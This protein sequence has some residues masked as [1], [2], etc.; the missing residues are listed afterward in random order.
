MVIE[1][2]R[3]TAVMR[4][5]LIAIFTGIFLWAVFLVF[6]LATGGDS[7]LIYTALVGIALGLIG[8]R[9]TIRRGRREQI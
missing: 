1:T 9:Y 5:A 7:K 3:Y 8:V 6:V 2:G 4:N